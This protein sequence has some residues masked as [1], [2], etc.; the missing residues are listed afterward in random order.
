MA[1]RNLNFLFK[2]IMSKINLFQLIK[3]KNKNEK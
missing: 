2:N 1:V 3:N